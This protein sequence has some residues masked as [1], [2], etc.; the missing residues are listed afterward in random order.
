MVCV[1]SVT[2]TETGSGRFESRPKFRHPIADCCSTNVLNN[3]NILL[4]YVIKMRDRPNEKILLSE[5]KCPLMV[6]PSSPFSYREN[7][8]HTFEDLVYLTTSSPYK[9]VLDGIPGHGE[10]SAIGT[11]VK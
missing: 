2:V 9:V 10:V 1:S 7:V 8:C 6:K 5:K 4:C 3:V 11:R